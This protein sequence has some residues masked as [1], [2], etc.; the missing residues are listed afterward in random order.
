MDRFTAAARLEAQAAAVRLAAIAELIDRRVANQG[1]RA[2][3]ACDGW[4]ECNAEVGAA[5]T[6]STY[7]ASIQMSNALR[8]RDDL[9]NVGA[10]LADGRITADMATTICWRS[11]LVDDP[12][13]LAELDAALSGA[14]ITWGALSQKELKT[15]LDAIIERIDP[16]AVIKTRDAVRERDVQLGKPDDVTGTRSIYGALTITDAA[17]L[18]ERITTM[19]HAVCADDP[20]NLSQRRSDAMGVIGAG[21]WYLEVLVRQARLCGGAML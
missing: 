13:T 6:I 4:A 7:W 9:P 15:A 19:V 16:A 14:V 12:T 11:Q 18:E 5:L 20:R 2:L 21:R 1:E 8:L 3:W 17:V 10:L